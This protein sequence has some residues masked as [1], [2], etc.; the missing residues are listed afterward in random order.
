MSSSLCVC[1]LRRHCGCARQYAS[2]A[3][4]VGAACVARRRPSA[5]GRT[6][7][8]RATRSAPAAH[9]RALRIDE[10]ELVAVRE[11]ERRVGL[12]AHADPVD[13]RRVRA[14][15]R[16]SRRRP[17]SRARAARRSPAAS[18]WSSG[19]PP[20]QTTSGRPPTRGRRS[21]AA[22]ARARRRR[23]RRRSRTCR[24]PDR[25][26]RSRCRR[27]GRR[28]AARS[29]SRPVHRLQP[30]KRQNTAGRPAFAP[31]A[32]QR[33]EDLLDGV[34]PCADVSVARRAAYARRDRA[35]PASAK[36]FRRSWQAS[37]WP[38]AAPSSRRIV[39]AQRD[40]RSRRRA[41]GRAR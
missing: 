27:T 2:A 22:S 14:A 3:L 25:R 9:P 23:A 5:G 29:A 33:V 6:P 30:E 35:T 16:S 24:R 13:A 38:H 32:L 1:R 36:P 28:R 18:S 11:H 15:C 12:G 40:A 34:R 41:R 39:A 8:S 21:R 7:R 20:V 26:R 37:Q 17:R 10:L 4:R 31:L 19:S